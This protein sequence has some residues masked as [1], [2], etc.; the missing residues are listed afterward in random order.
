VVVGLSSDV[1]ARGCIIARMLNAELQ[2][3][4]ITETLMTL[5]KR[6][7]KRFPDSG[8]SETCTDL[9]AF[10][11]ATPLVTAEIGQPI[12]WLRF[13]IGGFLLLVLLAFVLTISS[14]NITV[15]A[16]ELG[17]LVGLLEATTNE[18][19]LLAAGIFSLSTIETRVKRARVVDALNRLRA[20]AH[21]VDM[22]QLSKDPDDPNSQLDDLQ[23]GR[24]LDY[25]SEMLALI[26]KIGFLYIAQFDDPDANQSVNELETLT[27]GL[28]RKIWQ[29]IAILNTR[30][31]PILGLERGGT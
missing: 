22:K 21:I 31:Q 10:S 15:G 12:W 23:L 28:S 5:Q 13:C 17:D 1:V 3:E 11:R 7:D 4:K 2:A 14:L 9:I 27:T 24:Y 26:S 30:K 8:L 16:L 19:V 29:K 18:I 25:C 20:V 6:I